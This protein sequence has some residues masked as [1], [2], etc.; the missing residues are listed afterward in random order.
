MDDPACGVCPHRVDD[1]DAIALRFC[2]ATLAGA[3]DRGCV[4]RA[5]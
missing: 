4:C 1:H 5:G 2:R 3:L